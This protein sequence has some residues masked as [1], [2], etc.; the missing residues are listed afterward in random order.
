MT[1]G[2][3]EPNT[4]SQSHPRLVKASQLQKDMFFHARSF[5]DYLLYIRV[6]LMPSRLGI[7]LAPNHLTSSAFSL[8]GR[9]MLC[10]VLVFGEAHQIQQLLFV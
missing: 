10:L 7:N 1:T 5:W 4:Y 8:L 9:C 3:L 2:V 6:S